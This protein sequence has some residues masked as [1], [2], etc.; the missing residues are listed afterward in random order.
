MAN[1]DREDLEY[2]SQAGLYEP[3]DIAPV[4]DERDISTLRQ[5]KRDADELRRVAGDMNSIDLQHPKLS[6]EQQ[7]FAYQFALQFL[8]PHLAK[9][10]SAVKRVKQQG[11]GK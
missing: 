8:E 7:V 3:E 11:R 10:D 1:F 6:A 9:I 2:T 5:L 4:E